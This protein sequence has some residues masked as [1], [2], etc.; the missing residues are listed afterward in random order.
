MISIGVDLGQRRDPSAI[1][2]VERPEWVAGR[3]QTVRQMVTDQRLMRG[4]MVVRHLERVKL[5]TPYSQVVKRVVEVARHPCLGS[6]RRKLLVDATGVGAPVI[7]MLRAERPGC[8]LTPVVITGGHSGRRDGGGWEM[9]PKT[10]LL[11][12][13]QASLENGQLRIA[14]DMRET[15]RLVQEMVSLGGSEHDDLAMAVALAVWGAKTGVMY[16]YRRE[17]FPVY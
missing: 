6:V 11:A 10:D 12:A 14:R 13:T 15:G 17:F 4:D 5:G 7:E 16:G 2:V 8:E 1:A 9:V 3:L